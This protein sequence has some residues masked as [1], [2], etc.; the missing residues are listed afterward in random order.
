MEVMIIIVDRYN[1]YRFT[2]TSLYRSVYADDV[3]LFSDSVNTIKNKSETLIEAGRDIGLEINAEKTKY[4]IMSRHQN[5]GQNQNISIANVSF[6]K[7]TKFK[8]LGMTLTNQNDIHN[9][10]KSRLNSG[11]AFY[12]SV[13]NL[14][15][16]RL[17]SKNLKIKIYK[18]VILPVVLYGCETWSLTLGEEHRLRGFENR[19]LR[20]IFGPKREEDRSW[21]KL[22]NDE[23][24]SLYS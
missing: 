8:Y 19:V 24:H 18:I 3:N 2:G 14:S 21:R 17:I 1:W 6:E 13:Q 15:S 12:Y 5:S 10:I 7:V 20:T 23:L 11:N 22:H 16:S 4:M 9:E